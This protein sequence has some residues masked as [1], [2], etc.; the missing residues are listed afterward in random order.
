MGVHEIEIWEMVG[1][2]PTCPLCNGRRVVR[3]AWASWNGDVREWELSAVFDAM[4]CDKCGEITPEFK[5]D[6]AFRRKRIRRLN[7]AARRG[8]GVNVTV[9]MTTGVQGL[10]EDNAKAAIN[11]IAGFDSFTEDNDPHGEH[12]F[13]A[14]T[15]A[16]QKLFWKIDYFDLRLQ[17][18][19]P[20]KANPAVT[21]RVLTIML[22]SEY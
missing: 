21:S 17:W 1:S 13:G 18:H 3:D 2:Y 16:D 9:V 7:D 22:A 4:F 19:S 10:G 15:I 11:A 20:D 5:L 12:D 6:D 8:E 14:I